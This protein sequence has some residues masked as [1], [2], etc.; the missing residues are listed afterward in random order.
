VLKESQYIYPPRA[1]DAIP[2]ADTTTF[3]KLGF[4]AQLKYNDTRTLIKYCTNG[5]IELWNRHAQKLKTYT[6]TDNLTNQLRELA[7]KLN[8]NPNRWTL[9]DGGLLDHKHVAIRNTIA[10]WDILVR[11]SEH[12]LGTTY[13]ERYNFLAGNLTNG[14][15][16]YYHNPTNPKLHDPLPIG[17]KISNSILMPVNY[18]P[19]QTPWDTNDQIEAW[20]GLWTGIINV[21]N[22]PYT[23]QTPYDCKPVIEGLVLKLPTAKL[24]MGYT[25][26]NNTEWMVKT[27]VKTGRHQ[28]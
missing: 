12:L 1:K 26:K 18:E 15:T 27:R 23:T 10:I 20:K 5:K 22:A 6:P 3:A 2:L 11:D 9:L 28:F 16:W 8:L 14:N 4:K 25:E 19:K 24:K 21:A 7:D 17:L 13:I